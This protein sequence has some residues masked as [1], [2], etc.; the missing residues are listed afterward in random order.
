MYKWLRNTHLLLGLGVF[1]FLLMYALSALQ[2]SHPEWFDLKPTL[3]RERISLDTHVASSARAVAEKL[4]REH[5][6]RGDVTEVKATVDG[7][8][9]R[10]VRPGENVLVDYS[11]ASGV[12]NLERLALGF[13]AF[14]NRFHQSAG[15]RHSYVWLNVWGVLSAIVSIALILIS[16]T[17][18]YLWFKLQQER[19]TGAIL[20]AV[21]IAFS[22]TLIV[23]LRTA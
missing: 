13:M 23:L 20:M 7:F 1:L 14:I 21:C 12:A 19:V 3:T 17:G 8:R 5:G 22:L 10:I 4:M 9:F 15:V 11:R 2:M 6:L 16:L 18:I